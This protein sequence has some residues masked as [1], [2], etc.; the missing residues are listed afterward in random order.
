MGALQQD[1]A[2]VRSGDRLTAH[3]SRDWDIWGPNGGYVSAIAL[4]AAGAVAPADHRPATLSVQYLSPGAFEE[5]DCQVIPVKKGRNAWLLNVSLA[6]NGRTFLQAQV[7]TTNKAGGPTVQDAVM[8][9]VAPPTGLKT[10][11]EHLG[12]E[13]VH[14]MGGFWRNIECKPL[15]WIPWGERRASEAVLREWHRLVDY[16][17]A[18]DDPFLDACRS[19][20]LIDTL[21]WPTHHRCLPERPDYVAP[22]LDLTVWFHDWGRDERLAPG[23]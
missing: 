1:T 9:A 18:A 15:V 13:R 2:I 11:A 3:L 7:W 6:Q 22:S 8:P 23:R 10:V 4:R 16:Q 14:E 19:V 21:I 12:P 20:V 5:A 17:G